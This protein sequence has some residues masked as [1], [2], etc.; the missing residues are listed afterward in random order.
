MSPVTKDSI[1]RIGISV[2]SSRRDGS[3]DIKTLL[4]F[5]FRVVYRGRVHN[6][7]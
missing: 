4:D 1:S 2:K 6:G 3:I 7:L 5:Y